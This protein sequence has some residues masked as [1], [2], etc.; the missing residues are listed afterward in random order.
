MGGWDGNSSGGPNLLVSCWDRRRGITCD[1]PYSAKYCEDLACRPRIGV[2]PVGWG[3]RGGGGAGWI[4]ALMSFWTY[5]HL[6][7]L[8]LVERLLA[9]HSP[10]LLELMVVQA[11]NV[12]GI[13][14]KLVHHDSRQEVWGGDGCG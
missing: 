2:P 5:R 3:G 12:F 4:L 7:L 1:P 10:V 8:L 9:S 6:V 13:P 14:S 11:A